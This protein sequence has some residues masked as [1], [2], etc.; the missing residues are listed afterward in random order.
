MVVQVRARVS[1]AGTPSDASFYGSD[2]SKLNSGAYIGQESNASSNNKYDSA[3]SFR[4]RALSQPLKPSGP[5][6][7]AS[8]KGG[9]GGVD[10]S[11]KDKAKRNSMLNQLSLP[12]PVTVHQS[13]IAVQ[14][15]ARKGSRL[16]LQNELLRE[17]ERSKN[18]L[19]ASMLPSGGGGNFRTS[20]MGHDRGSFVSGGRSSGG[21]SR[22]RSTAASIGYGAKISTVE[23]V[24][25][26]MKT[27]TSFSDGSNAPSISSGA[28]PNRRE[29]RGSTR[30]PQAADASDG[31]GVGRKDN[32]VSCSLLRSSVVR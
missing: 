28:I 16:S 29:N 6:S 10:T 24:S 31:I 11:T 13:R 19:S 27:E 20:F 14:A 4:D 9:L 5:L 25:V 22:A 12:R 26:A 32:V 21:R 30:L 7:V 15:L 1:S 23:R 18:V 17:K 8:D 2:N 3:Q